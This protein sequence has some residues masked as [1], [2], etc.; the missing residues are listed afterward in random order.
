MDVAWTGEGG[1]AHEQPRA[2]LRLGPSVPAS[3][4]RAMKAFLRRSQPSYPDFT[5]GRITVPRTNTEGRTS[6]SASRPP[7]HCQRPLPRFAKFYPVCHVACLPCRCP[8]SSQDDESDT[9]SDTTSETTS[10][11]SDTASETASNCSDTASETTSDGSDSASDEDN[12]DFHSSRPATPEQSGQS[13]A[14]SENED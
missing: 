7:Q 3:T 14:S 11:G 6:D 4:W 2:Y 1:A 13:D 8:R 5:A 9:G 10:D 12:G